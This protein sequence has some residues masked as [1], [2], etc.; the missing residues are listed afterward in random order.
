MAEPKS[1]YFDPN[2]QGLATPITG[3]WKPAFMVGEQQKKEAVIKKQQEAAAKQKAVDDNAKFGEE[4]FKDKFNSLDTQ[5]NEYKNGLI[6]N[7]KEAYNK[8]NL[9][10]SAQGKS[11]PLEVRQELDRQRQDVVN[12]WEQIETAFNFTQGILKQAETDKE[13]V[14]NVE[15]FRE[16]LMDIPQKE[17]GTTD[18]SKYNEKY[19]EQKIKENADVL[20]DLPKAAEL[21]AKSLAETTLA[22]VKEYGD[23]RYVEVADK[24]NGL[25]KVHTDKNGKPTLYNKDGG[26]ELDTSNEAIAL[27]RKNKFLGPA[28]DAMVA[29][30]KAESYA[31]AFKKIA[32]GQVGVTQDRN[33]GGSIRDSNGSGSGDKN[34]YQGTTDLLRAAVGYKRELDTAAP[35]AL[36]DGE[37][38]F[39]VR[40]LTGKDL[41]KPGTPEY[42]REVQNIKG[43]LGDRLVPGKRNVPQQL[44]IDVFAGEDYKKDPIIKT[45]TFDFKTDE[46]KEIFLL[47]ANNIL[48]NIE[49]YKDGTMPQTELYKEIERLRALQKKNSGVFE[50]KDN[51]PKS[52]IF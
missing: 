51:K 37:N 39:D 20:Y 52:G 15:A 44:E 24:A 46:Q 36:I 16:V 26:V 8:A 38:V 3:L 18:F 21:Y 23:G 33:R 17:D 9:E 35:H 48:K 13:G 40:Y 28:M 14:H 45:L 2:N 41:Y 49:R 43:D 1:I 7:L 11:I 32:S 30:G 31:D 12:N 22:S 50:S 6:S 25:V 42:N 29:K 19:V 34:K 47:E 27:A 4:L 10:F 5:R